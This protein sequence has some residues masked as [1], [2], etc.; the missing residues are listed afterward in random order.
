[1]LELNPRKLLTTFFT[2]ICTFALSVNSTRLTTNRFDTD[3]GAYHK[4]RSQSK[5]E[6]NMSP[7]ND[8]LNVFSNNGRKQKI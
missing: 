7:I 6:K 2:G 4:H 3:V 1:M 5:K 8:H